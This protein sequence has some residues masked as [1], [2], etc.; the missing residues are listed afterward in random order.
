M[1][2]DKFNNLAENYEKYR[3]FYPEKYIEE[4][5][6]KCCLNS[7]SLVADIGAGTGILSRQFLEKNLKVIGVE[8]NIDM[9]KILKK[10]EKNKNFKAINGT[11]EYTKLEDNSVDL[12]VVAQAFHWFDKEA[13]KKECQRI[14]KP[15]G[16]V[17]I[18]WNQ[19][20]YT[21]DIAKE[22]KEIDDIYTKRFQE[23]N[24]II[25][26]K[27][28]N[29]KEFFGEDK[30]EKDVVDNPLEND[31]E[32]FIGVNLTKSY[33]LK[34]E[35]DNYQNYVKAFEKLF[36]KYSKDGKIIMPNKTYGYLGKLNK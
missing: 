27:E 16:R 30:Y 29:I 31:K 3:P 4:I 11:A 18:L 19:L 5:I 24:E 25:D 35:D 20:D 17:W 36:D 28:K 6:T 2:E 26:N 33:S 12:I 1:N 10:L 22:Q 23:V 21:K 14:L 15:N 9:R 8:P 7:D 13:F 34:K 32:K